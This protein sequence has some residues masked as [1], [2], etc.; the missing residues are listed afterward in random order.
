MSRPHRRAL[1]LL[2]PV[3]LLGLA[4]CGPK[5]PEAPAVSIGEQAVL[6][7]ENI[8]IADYTPSEAQR[9]FDVRHYDLTFTVDPSRCHVKARATIRGKKQAGLDRLELD[10]YDNLEVTGVVSGERP[11]GFER[12]TPHRLLVTLPDP[13]ATTFAVTVAYHGCPVKVHSDSEWTCGLL[14]VAA[15]GGPIINTCFQPFFARSLFPCKD[16]PSDKAE[17]GVDITVTVP[18][19]LRVVATGRRVAV[20]EDAGNRT[21]HWRTRYAVATNL[22]SFAAAAFAEI[23]GEYEMIDGRKLAI[24]HFVRPE[25]E[26]RAR[27]AF[28]EAPRLLRIYEK[29]FGPFPFAGDKYCLVETSYDGLENQTAIAYGESYPKEK[30]GRAEYDYTLVHETAHE[31]AGNA[32]TC[33]DWRDIWLHEGI[34][35]YAEGLYLEARDGRDAYLDLARAWQ[36]RAFAGALTDRDVNSDEDIFFS[37]VV[38]N[39]APAVLHM[40][41]FCLGDRAFLN[42][43]RSFLTDPALRYGNAETADFRR[44]MEKASGRRLESFFR[45][46]VHGDG[47]FLCQYDVVESPDQITVPIRSVSGRPEPHR[48]PVVVRLESAGGNRDQ[49]LD[50]GPEGAV[51]R[52]PRPG[53]KW[54]VV[55]D[56]ESWLLRGHFTRE[57][58]LLGEMKGR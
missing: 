56:P 30:P 39:R 46:W 47:F 20:S 7:W 34:A 40:L 29:A 36:T 6:T 43:L 31:W 3:V 13:A 5:R 51:A 55:F 32:V 15:E 11:L 45:A 48:L 33:R 24:H 58:G 19:P 4:A 22:I 41:R 2:A 18:K 16:H 23:T 38:Y 25:N 9:R 1:L 17:E 35:T 54:R 53:A 8:G 44:A 42:G 28:A 49:R 57:P 21:E 14:F 10:F 27:E 12:A 26:A 37:P 50:V 52:F